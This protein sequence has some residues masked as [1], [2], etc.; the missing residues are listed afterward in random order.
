M[1]TSV[2][3]DLIVLKTILDIHLYE[4]DCHRTNPSDCVLLKVKSLVLHF[5]IQC[6]IISTHLCLFVILDPEDFL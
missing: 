6:Q 1:L 2:N 3:S 4:F 5:A